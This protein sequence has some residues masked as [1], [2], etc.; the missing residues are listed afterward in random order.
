MKT[1]SNARGDQCQQVQRDHPRVRS[2]HPDPRRLASCLRSSRTEIDG[3]A[4][5]VSQV[6]LTDYSSKANHLD[7]S[8]SQDF[9]IC[10]SGDYSISEAFP[11]AL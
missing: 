3:Y 8:I 11:A 6:L 2:S 7:I 1:L 5:K 4:L 10:I 9:E